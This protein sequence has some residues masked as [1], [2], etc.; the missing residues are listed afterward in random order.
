MKRFFRLVTLA[1]SVGAI[2]PL[3]AQDRELIIQSYNIDAVPK[4]AFQTIVDDFQ[5]ANPDIKVTVRTTTDKEKFKTE[6][7]GFLAS[8]QA[9]D[10]IT[11]FAGYRM[12]VFAGKGLLEPITEIFPGGS[13]EK[14]FPQAFKSASSYRGKVYLLPQS[15]Y[16]WAVY[17]NKEV[18]AKL[19][20]QTP[21]TWEEFLA[22]C[23]KLKAAG[24]APLSIGAKDPWTAGGW[25]DY[26][27]SAVNGGDFHSTLLSG[28][29]AYTDPKVKKTFGYL[30]DLAKK[31]YFI[32]NA[33]SLTWQA[34]ADKL[35]KGEAGM[36]LIGQFVQGQVPPG[37][38]VLD[39]FAFPIVGG[40]TKTTVDTPMDGLIL[41]KKAKNKVAAKKFLAFAATKAQQEAW[42][43][44]QGFL[45]AN[46]TVP[47]ADAT[48][49]KG[50]AMV[51]S[52]T[53]ALQFYDRDAPVEMASKGMQAII[54]I[55]GAPQKVDEILTALD[56]ERS[57]IYFDSGE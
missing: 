30:A 34:A 23:E 50:L 56:K 21:K 17:Y 20:L 43:K 42:A 6:V 2:A 57:R 16:W 22:V 46:F 11:W 44:P 24:V 31:G 4:A 19:K 39:F 33:T 3:T 29:V 26:M 25:F 41:P 5:K 13:F 38:D 37:K 18:F 51:K 1:L 45:A 7:P 32:P 27:D 35:I 55:L 12:Q 54:D 36:S 9:P 48:A 10:V 40:N 8:D 53:F 52:A 28:S 15:Y 47:V 49:Q 14:E